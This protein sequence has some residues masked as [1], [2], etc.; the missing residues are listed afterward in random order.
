M[1]QISHFMSRWI[2][3]ID[4]TRER[5]KKRQERKISAT[6]CVWQYYYAWKQ[7]Q[8]IL[9]A[10]IYIFL[11]CCRPYEFSFLPFGW[12][13]QVFFSY[14]RHSIQ[15]YSNIC[16]E[17]RKTESMWGVRKA[18]ENVQSIVVAFVLSVWLYMCE[19]ACVC[20]LPHR[21]YQF[22]TQQKSAYLRI[23]KQ[24]NK[25]CIDRW[26]FFFILF[27]NNRIQNETKP[28]KNHEKKSSS[29]NAQETTT[30]HQMS[31]EMRKKN[32][33]HG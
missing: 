13:A 21:P 19:R 22:D 4:W 9:H 7:Y 24:I 30:F 3:K 29:A 12:F 26:W 8:R 17:S 5:E 6:L 14:N 31:N 1:F 33:T 25:S 15:M 23:L 20:V 11:L 16:W 32:H 18:R 27:T 10:S 28:K 2:I